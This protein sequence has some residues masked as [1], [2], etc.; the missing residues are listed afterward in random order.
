MQQKYTEL[1]ARCQQHSSGKYL[2]Y[3]GTGAT[4][5]DL[6]AMVDAL[7]GPGAPVNYLGLS[8]GTVIGSWLVNSEYHGSNSFL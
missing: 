5:R 7:D 8:Y 1:G 2:K 4:V 6:L 3:M